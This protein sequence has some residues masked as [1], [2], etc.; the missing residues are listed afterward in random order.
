M[1][2]CWVAAARQRADRIFSELTKSKK[3]DPAGYLPADG[4]H[5][6]AS[7]FDLTPDADF[8]QESDPTGFLD[9]LSP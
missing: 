7:P 9:D 5:I 2:T 3:P 8:L 6:W 4:T 1:D